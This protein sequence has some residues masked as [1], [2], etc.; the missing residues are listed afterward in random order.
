MNYSQLKKEE[1]IKIIKELQVKK[2]EYDKLLDEYDKLKLKYDVVVNARKE[3]EEKVKKA[4]DLSNNL[5][6]KINELVSHYSSRE[7]LMR[8]DLNEQNATIINLLVMLDQTIKI[9]QLYFKKYRD[10]LIEVNDTE[11]DMNG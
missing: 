1:L 4:E 5:Q 3:D 7:D 9:Q 10:L 8:K 2:D 11:V 6:S